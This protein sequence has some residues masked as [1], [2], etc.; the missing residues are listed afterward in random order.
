[1]RSLPLAAA[2]VAA[3]SVLDAGAAQAQNYPY[4][5]KTG[6]GPGNC[7]YSTYRQCQASASGTG[8]YCQPNYAL[9]GAY[10]RYGRTPRARYYGPQY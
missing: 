5:L 6:P 1:M 3:A 7:M 8:Y 10:A 4:C 9:R 2:V